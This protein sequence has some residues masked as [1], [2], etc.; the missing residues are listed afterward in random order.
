MSNYRILPDGT[1][2]FPK[3]GQAPKCPAGFVWGSD[4]YTFIP[5]IKDCSFRILREFP[6]DCGKIILKLFCRKHQLYINRGICKRCN[7]QSASK[8][9]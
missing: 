7:A 8:D 9:E 3:R 5:K 1:I 4:P 2:W 6:Q